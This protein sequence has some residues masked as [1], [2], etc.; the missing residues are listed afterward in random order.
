MPVNRPR[1]VHL[2]SIADLRA[3]A[4]A[5]DDLWQR[6][7]VTMPTARA[8]TLAQWLD[9]FAPQ[10]DFRALVV[11]DRGQWIAA[12]PLVH[13]K[14]GRIVDAGVL[15]SNEWSLCGELLLDPGAEADAALDALVAALDELPWPLVWLDEVPL[16]TPRWQALMEAVKRAGLPVDCRGQFQMG[17]I[18]TGR[19]WQ[20]Y[21][22]QWSRKH[23]QGT[24][25]AARRLAEEG[26]VQLRF[27]SELAEQEV[28]PYLRRGFEIEDRSWKG[29]AGTSVLRT[30]GMFDFFRR[31]AEQLAR[32]GQ[33]ELGFL[34]IDGRP[35][36]FSYGPA[37]KGVYHSIKIG[38]D[39]AY[40]ACRPGHLLRYHTLER[41]FLDP[42][43]HAIDYMVPIE[44]QRKWRPAVYTVSRMVIAP[45]GMLG[46]MVLHAYKNWWPLVRRL[47]HKPSDPEQHALV[48]SGT[49]GVL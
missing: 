42:A 31:Q 49:H 44:V 17:R 37:A 11:E 10:A 41:L 19:D 45:R 48:P 4:A 18:E 13:R 40:A 38:Y 9:Q 15:P 1:L 43:W 23:R 36:A 2:A 8:E 30:P 16:D 35:I 34:E 24:A 6:S 47:R 22:K 14:L 7:E 26:D 20:I 5:W 32:W 28:E 12:L 21:R 25:R 39:P 27:I 33:L 3:A 29:T 46:R